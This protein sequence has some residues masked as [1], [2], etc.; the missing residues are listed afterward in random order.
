MVRPLDVQQTIL[1]SNAVERVQ[2]VQQQHPDI[3]QRYFRDQLN[4]EKSLL[5]KKVKDLEETERLIIREKEKEDKGKKNPMGSKQ[6]SKGEDTPDF[7]SDL[8]A[9]QI[10]GKVDIRV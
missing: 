8:S 10:G 2:Q 7:S 9:E 4:K 5:E 1:Q 3:Q 6:K